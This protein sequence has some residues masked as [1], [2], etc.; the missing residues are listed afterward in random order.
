MK[1]AMST[2]TMVNIFEKDNKFIVLKEAIKTVKD[3]DSKSIIL[4]YLDAYNVVIGAFVSIMKKYITDEN[5]ITDYFIDFYKEALY[6]RAPKSNLLQ[7]YNDIYISRFKK[8]MLDFWNESKE[9]VLLTSSNRTFKKVFDELHD[10]ALI[11][12]PKIFTKNAKGL[13]NLYRC[14]AGDYFGDYKRLIP[15][16]K[17]AKDNRWNH[18]DK[19]YLYVGYDEN[20]CDEELINNIKRTCFKEVRLTE[21]SYATL[22]KFKVNKDCI[23]LNLCIDNNDIE[24]QDNEMRNFL[25]DQLDIILNDN[26]LIKKVIR[27]NQSGNELQSKKEIEKQI[28]KNSNKNIDICMAEK[29]IAIQLIHVIVDAIFIPVEKNDDPTLEAYIPFRLFADYLKDKGYG[30]II[31]KSTRNKHGKNIVIF[32]K[33]DTSTCDNSMELYQRKGDEYIKIR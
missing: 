8:D 11:K 26:V 21:G 6:Y 28:N 29:F 33:D 17:Y 20:G 15:N 30:G 19:A 3:T 16:D 22:C 1:L 31:Y 24:K 14:A 23:L 10:Y 25:N 4:V 12:Y 32:E 9:T 27:L 7:L 13:T 5:F 2:E 18:P